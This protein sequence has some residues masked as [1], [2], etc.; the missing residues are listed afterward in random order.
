MYGID[1]IKNSKG[2][3]MAHLNIRSLTNKW[4]NFKAHFMNKNLHVLGLSETWLNDKLPNDLFELTNCYQ[5]YRNDR[6]WRDNNSNFIKKG[7]GV[8]LFVDSSLYSSDSEFARLNCSNRLL[9]ANGS[10]LSKIITN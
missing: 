3:H 8:G 10:P 4:E 2:M 6:S 9:K 7:G 5:F 1:E